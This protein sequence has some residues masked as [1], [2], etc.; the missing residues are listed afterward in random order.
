MA[1]GQI[2][3][4]EIRPFLRL[5]RL[6]GDILS[7]SFLVQAGYL[8]PSYSESDRQSLNNLI[9]EGLDFS[10]SGLVEYHLEACKRSYQK[11]LK[12]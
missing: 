5:S 10:T 4:L 8:L 7:Y 2:R 12:G 11:A 1:I 3:L 6:T 9:E